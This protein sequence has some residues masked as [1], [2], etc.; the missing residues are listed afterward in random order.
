MLAALDL[1]REM[2]HFRRDLN[3]FLR[4]A[5]PGN[6][7]APVAGWPA[8]NMKE[9]QD[10]LVLELQV[11]GINPEELDISV[12]QGSLTVT[13]ERTLEEAENRT[14]HRRERGFGKFSRT[15]E[16]PA[17]VDTDK[18]SAAFKD[19]I[20]RV[21]LPKAETAKPKRIEISMA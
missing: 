20:L 2:D 8:A 13:G 9:T 6:L 10:G 14:W 1:F 11:P 7:L 15:F 18:V 3:Q 21:K 12:K 4:N 17:E 19:G 5:E 16:L